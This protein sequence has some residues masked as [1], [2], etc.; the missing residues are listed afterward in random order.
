M[1]LGA[2]C[3]VVQSCDEHPAVVQSVSVEHC[4][5]GALG[6]SFGVHAVRSKRVIKMRERV[7]ICF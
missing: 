6:G 7:F 1:M 5:G 2:S 4:F 3:V